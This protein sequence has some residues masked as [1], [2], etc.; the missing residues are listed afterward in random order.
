MRIACLGVLL[1]ILSVPALS[2]TKVSANVDATQFGMRSLSS[3]GTLTVTTNGTSNV[4][5]N[6]PGDFIANDGIVIPEAGNA[7]TQS[8]PSAPTVTT[9]GATGASSIS[10]ECVGVDSEWGMTAASA[11]GTTT[12]APTVFGWGAIGITSISRVSNVVSVVTSSTMP[13]SSGTYHAAIVNVTGGTTNFEGLFLVTVN[14]STT[15]SYS[16]TGANESGTVTA[17]TTYLLF[18]NAF[19]LVTVSEVAGSNTITIATDSTHNFRNQLLGVH[20]TKLFLD[21]IDFA[22]EAKAGYANGLFTVGI[23]TSTTI[24]VVT[25][26]TATLTE[27]ATASVTY[28]N[29]GV[30]QMT[31]TVWASQLVTC[32]AISGSTEY[33]A[34]Y[35]NYGSGYAPIGFTPW[36]HNIF[37]DYGP[38][39]TETGF[40]A[41][42]AMELPSMPPS[43]AIDQAFSA[44]VTG[45][46]GSTLTL[47]R[48][49]PQSVS[50]A[51]AYHDNGAALQKA[52]S[53]SCPSNDYFAPVY[54]PSP[55][56]ASGF[57]LISA[58]V[59]LSGQAPACNRVSVIQGGPI[60]ANGTIYDPTAALIE[61]VRSDNIS[62]QRLPPGN[63]TLGQASVDGFADPLF[64]QD[65]TWHMKGVLVHTNSNGQNGIVN[66][67]VMSRY[68]EMTIGQENK[69]LLSAV[70]MYIGGSGFVTYLHNVSFG[71]TPNL[72]APVGQSCAPSCGENGQ[73]V[74]W[75]VPEI[76]IAGGPNNMPDVI[77]DGVNYGVARGVQFDCTNNTGAS[78]AFAQFSNVDTFQEPWQPFIQILGING[79]CD[80]NHLYLN[81]IVM[82]SI[83]MPVIGST[84]DTETFLDATDLWTVRGENNSDL[85][86]LTGG[87]FYTVNERQSDTSVEPIQSSKDYLISVRAITNTVP[88]NTSSLGSVT[89]CSSSASP[90]VCGSA[91]AGSFVIAASASSVVV[92]TTAITANSQVLIQAD[93]SLGTKLGVKCN[94][95]ASLLA[96]APWVSARSAGTSFTVTISAAPSTNPECFNYEVIN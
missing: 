76:N 51:T 65:T 74:W 58:P 12:T 39:F 69:Y 7:T 3:P 72:G 83:Q 96:A 79:T 45:M 54:I 22:G 33:Y 10:Y 41:P 66:D 61:W 87:Q 38:A 35:A 2:Q 67:G 36:D 68:E 14:S 88:F 53:F 95:T 92:D 62:W 24:T 60:F 19:D 4:S 27:N 43:S 44:Q 70:G 40:T 8:T 34:V 46:T 75:P 63:F 55:A 93:D 25:P 1:A 11:A 50:G 6:G 15:L 26:Y 82:D 56:T 94:T 13:V 71:G 32:P 18:E 17:G 37:E 81:N 29:A 28:S 91:M 80:P 57:Y 73:V 20:P 52:I 21:G 42:P 85:P 9:I 89:N 31:A 30:A 47:D 77:W 59:N 64:G 49:V 5:S 16:Q 84:S 78:P 86:I 48:S 90:A 23:V